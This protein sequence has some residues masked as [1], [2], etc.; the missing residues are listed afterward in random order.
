MTGMEARE[1]SETQDTP[2]T[3]QK[4]EALNP[5]GLLDLAA[6]SEVEGRLKD[7]GDLQ[8]LADLYAFAEGRAPDA[9]GGRSVWL[10]AG[11]FWLHERHDA[12]RAETLLRK[13]LGTGPED[14]Q[15]LEALQKVCL[16]AERWEEAVDT[17]E[18]LSQ[19]RS[20]PERAALLVRAARVAR[21]RL[22]HPD[23]ALR[24]LRVAYDADRLNPQVLRDAVSL[25][26]EE[27]RWTEIKALLDDA[28]HHVAAA[29]HS[30][31]ELSR[32]Y[33]EL[34]RRCMQHAVFHGLAQ[35]AF[36]EARRLGDQQALQLLDRLT[37]VRADWKAR[38]QELVA[39]GLETRDKA[40]AAALYV[41]AAE[42]CLVYGQDALKAEEHLNR[43]I[44]LRGFDPVLRYLE[45]VHQAQ[46][47]PGEL[48]RR[49]NDLLH[50]V[51]DLPTQVRIRFR[52]ARLAAESYQPGLDPE[53]AMEA[54]RQ[55]LSLDPGHREATW[56]AAQ[57]WTELGRVREAADLLERHLATQTDPYVRRKLHLHL[58]HLHAE[59]LGDSNRARGHF[60]AVLQEGPHLT[61]ATALRA[62][63]KDAG[64]LKPLLE[65]QRVLVDAMPDAGTRRA[66]LEEMAPVAEALGPDEAFAVARL[67]FD[68]DPAD[69][70]IRERFES[71]GMAQER[72]ATLAEAFEDAAGRLEGSESVAYWRAA[73]RLYDERLPRPQDALRCYRALLRREPNDSEAQRALEALLRQQDDPQA[74]VEL[75]GVQLQQASDPEQRRVLSV[76]IADVYDRELGDPDE[77]I[78]RLEEVLREEPH[79]ATA[80]AGLDSLYTR[81]GH[82][83]ALV[84][85]LAVRE[86]LSESPR[87]AADLALR[88]AELFER[89]LEQPEEAVGVYVSVLRNDERPEAV[90]GLQRLLA[91]G[92][93]PREAAK[94]LEQAHARSQDAV[95][96]VDMLSVL[97]EQDETAEQ[98][99]A[100]A[101]KA[102][103]LSA[104]RLRNRPASL[105]YLAIATALDPADEG[106]R[107][108]LVDL[109][110]ELETPDPA[111]RA[112]EGASKSGGP[113]DVAAAC[114]VSLGELRIRTHRLEEGAR[115][116]ARALELYPGHPV[117]LTQLQRLWVETGRQQDLSEL[118]VRQLKAPLDREGR[119]RLLLALAE[120]RAD[121][122]DDP[123]G[124]IEPLQEVLG[125]EPNHRVA[126][127]KL[128]EAFERTGRHDDLVDVLERWR[129][130]TEPGAEAAALAVRLGRVLAGPRGDPE[131]ALERF[132]QALAMVPEHE[133]A[134]R[135]LM[136]LWSDPQVGPRAAARVAPALQAQGRERERLAALEAQLPGSDPQARRS[137]Y[138]ALVDGAQAISDADRA[139]TYGLAAFSEGLFEVSDLVD[140][141]LQARR[142]SELVQ[143]LEAR[144]STQPGPER[145][146]ML[147]ALGRLA[148]GP[149]ADPGRARWAWEQVAAAEPADVEALEALERLSEAAGDP[150]RL[151]EVLR[152]RAETVADPEGKV[153]LLR[154][155][156]AQ[157]EQGARDLEAAVT[158][159]EEADRWSPDDPN[160]LAEMARLYRE[161][162]QFR[163]EQATL[164]RQLAGLRT[165]G[166]RAETRTQLARAALELSDPQRAVEAAAAA[167]DEV[168]G[169]PRAVEV[170]RGLLDGPAAAPAAHALEP[171]LR[172]SRDWSEL[173]RAYRVLADAAPDPHARVQRWVAIRSILEDRLEDREAAFDAAVRVYELSGRPEELQAVERIAAE[174]DR[175][176][177]YF[178]LLDRLAEAA[179][180]PDRVAWLHHKA[181]RVEARVGD[182]N[183]SVGPYR[184]VLEAD[185]GHVPALEALI[186]QYERLGAT[187]EL[188][189][190]V[191]HR[192]ELESDP[193]AR[194]PWLLRWAELA[195]SSLGD[196][197]SAVEAYEEVV[198]LRPERKDVLERLDG[199]YHDR[200]APEAEAANLERLVQRSEGEERLGYR[201]RLGLLRARRLDDGVGAS[202]AFAATVDESEVGSPYRTRAL[203]GLRNLLDAASEPE[204]IRRLA[205]LLEPAYREEARLPDVAH[206][207]EARI[208][209]E[210]DQDVRRGLRRTLA[211]LY[212]SALDRP[213]LAFATLAAAFRDR[214]GD[215]VED[216]L[217]ALGL[218]LETTEDVA[219]LFL[220]GARTAADPAT[221]IRLC[222]RAAGLCEA[223]PGREE[224]A[225]ALYEEIR[226]LDPTDRDALSALERHRKRT[227]DLRGLV[228]VYRQQLDDLSDPA[229]RATLWERIADLAEV[230]LGDVD[231]AL[232]ALAERR[233]LPDPDPG[234]RS[235]M[236]SLCER[237]GR[238]DELVRILQEVLE[239]TPDA[240]GQGGVWLRLA[241]IHRDARR[242][243]PASV[244]AFIEALRLRPQDP[245]AVQGL[246][247]FMRQGPSS[248][249][250]D[251]A[252][253]LLPELEA[254]G[255]DA[256]QVE[257][258]QVLA[259]S[260]SDRL[261]RKDAFARA[262]RSCEDRQRDEEAFDF[263][264]RALREDLA[265]RD[266]R[267][268]AENLAG[269]YDSWDALASVYQ[270]VSEQDLPPEE[271]AEIHVRL[272]AHHADR[273][274]PARAVA[275]L[276][277]ALERRPDH[278]EAIE[279]LEQLFAREGD[280]S[281]LVEVFRRRIA[282]TEDPVQR[283]SL[284][285][286]M[287]DLQ[288]LR[289]EDL[290]GAI[291]TLRRL[292]EL[293]P[294]DE[295]AL[296]RLD[297][298]LARAGRPT[299]RRE[300]LEQWTRVAEGARALA[301]RLRW[302]RLEAEQLSNPG[303][304]VDLA[305]RNLDQ[306]PADAESHRFLGELLEVAQAAQDRAS[307][308]RIASIL[309]SACQRAHDP[310]GRINALR[311]QAE[312][313]D[314]G[315][316]RADLWSRIAW[317]Y[318]E[319]LEQSDLAFMAVSRAVSAQPG[320][321]DLRQRF[322][323]LG[324]ELELVDEVQ[325]TYQ[326]LLAEDLAPEVAAELW[327]ALGR[328]SPDVDD[329]IGAWQKV[330][331]LSPEDRE[332]AAALE[333]LYRRSEKWAAL[334]E[335]LE[336]RA[337]RSQADPG[338][339]VQAWME[340]GH[341]WADR[342][343][344]REEALTAF[345][346]A[347]ALDPADPSVGRAL[348]RLLD[349]DS[350]GDELLEVLAT[351]VPQL[352]GPEA[353]RLA[354]RRAQLLEARD[355][356]AAADAYRSVLDRTPGHPTAWDGLERSL[357]AAGRWRELVDVLETRGLNADD[358]TTLRL[359]RKL[360]LIRGTRLGSAVEAIASWNELL[361]RNPNDLQA[362]EE[363]R[364]LHRQE[365]QWDGLVDVL[366]RLIPLQND[367][368]AIKQIRFE[369]AQVH[370]NEKQD[371]L[372]ATET[373]RRIL[374]I[375]PHTA[376][377]LMEL[378]ALFMRA[379]A[380][381]EAVKVL[382][383]RA[384]LLDDPG[385]QA[386]VWLQV[387]EIYERY[388]GRSAGAAQ[389]Y[390]RALEVRPDHPVAFEKLGALFEQ[391][392]D[393]RR[394][395]ELL[396]RRIQTTQDPD[397]RLALQL[398]VA[399]LQERWLGSKDLAFSAAC[400][401]LQ[402]S[403]FSET[404]RVAAERLADQTDNWDVLVDLYE[405]LVDE[406]PLREAYVL[407]LR[408]AEILLEHGTEPERAE[409]PLEMALATRPGD[410]RAS[411]L[412]ARLLEQQGRHRDL[413]IHL[414][415]QVELTDDPEVRTALWARIAELEEAA[416]GQIEAAINAWQRVLDL[417]GG[418]ERA[419]SELDRIYREED[420]PRARLDL[421]ERRLEGARDP[422]EKV[423]HQLDMAQLWEVDLGEIGHAIE[424]HRDVL[425]LDPRNL[426]ALASLERLY[427]QQERWADLRD[428]YRQ[429]VELLDSAA[430]R[431]DRWI[432]WSHLAETHLQ[433][434][435]EALEVLEKVLEAQPDHAAALGSLERLHRQREDWQRVVDLLRT[436]L[437]VT[438]E[439]QEQAEVRV[440]LAEV[441]HGALHRSEEAEAE[442]SRALRH[443]P[444]DLA[445][446]RALTE[447]R[448]EREDWPEMIELLRQQA[449]LLGRSAEAVELLHQVGG[450]QRDRLSDREGSRKT[451]ERAVEL[452]P[453]HRPTLEALRRLAAEE[454]RSEAALEWL[455]RLVEQTPDPEE[456]ADLAH[457]AAGEALDG[458][459]DVD[460]AVELLETS[461][462]AKPDHLDALL[463]ISELL[464]S[465]EQ[466]EKAEVYTARLVEYLDPGADRRE[467]CRQHYRLAYI[468]EKADDSERALRHYMRSYECD[469]S[470]LP[471]L[472]GLGAALVEAGRL[473]DAQRV[474][475]T[476]LVHHRASLTDAEVVDLHHTVGRLAMQLGQSDRA[477]KSFSKALEADPSH[478]ATLEDSARL[479]D[480]MQDPEGAYDARERLIH[481][482]PPGE[483]VAP[484][485]EQGTAC[486]DRLQDPY[487]AIDAFQQA[488]A[489][490]PEDPRILAALAPLFEATRQFAAAVE[491]WEAL[492]RHEEDPRRRVEI[493][494][495]IGRLR[496]EH[497]QDAEGAV[498]AYNQALDLDPSTRVALERIEHIL[499]ETR[500]WRALE[501]TYVDMIQRLPKGAKARAVM[502]RSIGDL[503]LKVTRDPV[504]A[505]KAFEVLHKL[506]PADVEV[507][508]QLATLLRQIPERKAEA[509]RICQ[510]LLPRV[511]DPAGPLR[512]LSELHYEMGHTDPSFCALGALV[513]MR[514]ASED[515]VRAY[516]ALAE[517]AASWPTGSLS[518][519]QWR[520]YVLHPE[521]RG[522][523][524]QICT[525]VARSLPDLFS[526]RKQEAQLQRKKE[527]VDLG[528]RAK[529]RPY[530]YE[531]WGR[532]AQALGLRDVE[533]YQ[534]P[535]SVQPPVLLFGRPPVLFAG[536][537]HG[538]FKTMP[539]RQLAWIIARQMACLRPELSLVR[540]LG[541]GDFIAAVEAAVQLV[542][543]RGSGV[544][545]PVDPRAVGNWLKAMRAAGADGLREHLDGPVRA[546]LSQGE[547]QRLGAYL[548]G[549]EHTASRAALLMCGDWVTAAR[550]LGDSDGLV[551][552]PYAR[553]VWELMQYTV[554]PEHHALREGLG[555][556]V[557]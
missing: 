273:Q 252:R 489:L 549:A 394:L 29:G 327:R 488:R 420:R 76:K 296:E 323:T 481:A 143:E 192:A 77:A 162:G 147:R 471:T 537:Q 142:A 154:R 216:D 47:R 536:G 175:L 483:R 25:L 445:A 21:E 233:K 205:D 70:G 478:V 48:V 427:L 393:H 280:F 230:E 168:P 528:A 217:V 516:R 547:L 487:R 531:V 262:A 470:Y 236:A 23:R 28:V 500:Q 164:E 61:A 51:S 60:E 125:M 527:R 464:F 294:E 293:A 441:L 210:T 71:L 46:S 65:V 115:A 328:M 426:E 372:M 431:V 507:G 134:I 83:E 495:D 277:L 138:G 34:G 92:I 469:N 234:I 229:E 80:L 53:P 166:A 555:I 514:I 305:E 517:R 477:K 412:M 177:D 366:R 43:A 490:A 410:P 86:A 157:M 434:P 52:M 437:S 511:D 387:G 32:D 97:I 197:A 355:P 539:P 22:D 90:E 443:R 509:V 14:P 340:L 312:A 281:G 212:G 544:A 87:E 169:H 466:W 408:T 409:R 391:N 526:G 103:E 309:Q 64:E 109:A 223:L 284:M 263:L 438:E 42:L 354:L 301:P 188:T 450:L 285:R 548:E 195:E 198:R 246:T 111:D 270:R 72:Y 59:R 259:E 400:A 214:P 6:F 243:P 535:G 556:R 102:A 113:A 422:R 149:A 347:R 57:L 484:L 440:A 288:A 342:L 94:A 300:V 190:T 316:E 11:L 545:H 382:G 120:V 266:L 449:D 180:G 532:V 444:D 525:V 392:G 100:H 167:L 522:A 423:R 151:A 228:D 338:E 326:T 331:A 63:Y 98:K 249:R 18:R 20:G 155:A 479:A 512:L 132:G 369:L 308:L 5:Q 88:R 370:L 314:A 37:V 467:L 439:P 378:E 254:T 272:G 239:A 209:V 321:P 286:Q 66:L 202:A 40:T 341:L 397:D 351:L 306:Q 278:P 251:A 377:E 16:E 50:S 182:P 406:L 178:A 128:A 540:A 415:D 462:E 4:S 250:P 405:D 553:R 218:Q 38:V 129:A 385:E 315:A 297:Q 442:L 112:L 403:P 336:L 256:E 271:A 116:F 24:A 269:R 303:Q 153:R 554:S 452:L 418:H 317:I 453:S 165:P 206:V 220:E 505:A 204:A 49:L 447:I 506:D 276:Q 390:E 224:E 430:D 225:A 380:Y 290:P 106:L 235:R 200:G 101:L 140:L 44:L 41:E 9:A 435:D 521:L 227:G 275:E 8:G 318:S 503:H 407:R 542:E 448:R 126:V 213:E 283:A 85:I 319:E 119:M 389:A 181:E 146:A 474:H 36:E 557:Q 546:A 221:R 265:D 414:R 158:L 171:W 504:Q 78:R 222:R 425:R 187:R 244:T 491:A 3:W 460:R 139:F 432:R 291:A 130:A 240:E 174:A 325:D 194:L 247:R 457:R 74:L 502:W 141:A 395:V 322:E 121:H 348:V 375:E 231:L 350:E 465:D 304:A 473:E 446:L 463:D 360:A 39:T 538:V 424:A 255:T 337:S 245:E 310:A 476:I 7:Q 161:T 411:E 384:E 376:N 183:R 529:S 492:L 12:R 459:D 519:S 428:V 365:G 533:H 381:G 399:E 543:P 482:L 530:Y 433:A 152:A 456:R 107:E 264:L 185:P 62:L 237:D 241:A 417:D 89:S 242:D 429:Q 371:P 84:G 498:R 201:V 475:Q 494:C 486:R 333:D 267:A 373:A 104:E 345:R 279:R 379:E 552:I 398:R 173:V 123:E 550:A 179:T 295:S 56:M 13:V 468:A 35:T 122:L 232:E 368:E 30:V 110:V 374:D 133:P 248:V 226:K 454:G 436:R 386:D 211:D 520:H 534:R 170:L 17:M 289:M 261:E 356:A 2:A 172:Q 114:A 352:D 108:R 127:A 307:I 10:R 99:K 207:L 396:Q 364:Q 496:W 413:G 144:A 343:S 260:S 58:G 93:K 480:T 353:E 96:R 362:L 19:Q 513:L 320:R 416:L 421:L 510:T 339:R 219:D 253:A 501:Q 26:F 176:D 451:F 27:R 388:I 329:A 541:A 363:L 311:A 524:G 302:A 105:E 508:L 135:G 332:A 455:V 298:L 136:D 79:H 117:A 299:E 199:I 82:V 287:A 499:F 402:E 383:R 196:S 145:T 518:D 193:E 357:E 67:A 189:A 54:L 186:R 238:W 551:E 292:V 367:A 55:V 184:A 148:D 335:I 159:W 45:N 334:A 358:Q 131:A 485:I 359:Q 493:L 461:L 330:R 458:F 313:V 472:E 324:A 497:E 33:R 68:Q 150:R 95:R 258:L 515:E 91:R 124:S 215:D 118:L 69:A 156:A 75:L 191:R 208:R 160:T 137:L 346:E 1:P 282:Q 404:A 257:A 15:A 344:E 73:A 274:D 268:R 203:D 401:A 31:E 163:A 419:Y 361:R 81:K 349:A 523:V